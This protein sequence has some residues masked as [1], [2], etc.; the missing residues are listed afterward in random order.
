MQCVENA[1]SNL[2]DNAVKFTKQGFIEIEAGIVKERELAICRIRDSGVGI[3]SEYLDH[4][5]QPFSQEDLNIGRSYEGNGL[6]LA[7]SK[8]YI[9]KMGGSLLVDSIKGVGSTFTFTLPLTKQ[10]EKVSKKIQPVRKGKLE[11]ILMVDDSSES[12]E[13]LQAYLKHL[14]ELDITNLGEFSYDKIKDNTFIKIIL[15]VNPNHW[16][17]GLAVCKKLK[18]N[19]IKNRPIIVI[20]S[21]YMEQKIQQFYTAGASK[22]IVKPFSKNDLLKS[23]E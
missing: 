2:L 22:F 6:G 8:R 1:I 19:D 18:E 13:L 16:E 17:K 5:F 7:L 3:S 10:A 11:K 20:S 14:Y 15:D 12:Y 21:E 4:L 23:L 9:E